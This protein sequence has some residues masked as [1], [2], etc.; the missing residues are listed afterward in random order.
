[1]TTRFSAFVGALSAAVAPAIAHADPG[2]PANNEVVV[3]GKAPDIF[4]RPSGQTVTGVGRDR[5]EGQPAFQIGDVLSSLPGVTYAFGNG[6]RDISIS[7]RGS[8]ARNTFGVRNVQVLEDGFALTQPDGLARTDLVDPHAYAAVDVAHGPSSALYG[9][10]ATGG[11]IL[12]RTR[13]GKDIDGVEIALDASSDGY[14]NAF[15]AFGFANAVF[16]GAGFLSYVTGDGFTQHT[17]YRTGT[18]NGRA[19]FSVT[20]KDRVVL[21]VINN[22]LR[23]DLSIRLSQAQF[24][25]NPFQV[26]CLTTATAGCA[27]I[28][29]FANGFN[30]TRVPLTADQAGLK[31]DDR[32]T[33]L[34]VRWEHDVDDATTWRSALVWD[35]RDINQPTSATSAVGT[36][37]SFNLTSDLT[38]RTGAVT[39]LGGVFWNR[40]DINSYSYNVMPGGNATLGG[41]STVTFGKHTNYG[42]R[43]RIELD[44]APQ[45]QV[46]GG[47][48]IERTELSAVQNAYTYPTTGSPTIARVFADRTYTNVA[49]E[50]SI[51][52]RPIENGRLYARAAG[53]Y[54]TPQATNLF[55]TPAGIPGNNTTLDAQ[56][57]KGIDIGVEWGVTDTLTVNVT[58]FYEW[59]RNELVS[60]SAGANLLNYTFNAPKSEHRGV[61]AAAEWRPFKGAKGSVAYLF[62]EQTYTEYQERLSAGAFSTQFDRAGKAIPGV[63]R[64]NVN[65]RLGYDAPAGPVR[66]LGG[67]VEM[68]WRESAFADNA[69]LLRTPGYTLFNLNAH[70]T[71]T[72][73]LGARSRL[74]FYVSAQNLTDRVYVS[75]ASNVANSISSATGL[76]NGAA[77]LYVA[78]GSIYAGQRRTVISGVKIKY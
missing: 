23:A 21:K 12:F 34:G 41:L 58:G 45:W 55:V 66:G 49:P 54:G 35:N 59:F 32:R 22:E 78:S 1:M 6:P 25:L 65:L 30:G 28:N 56:T 26:G 70:Y 62:N 69:N 47:V 29:A 18:L 5:I 74:Q 64:Q 46:V 24:R 39:L 52:Y 16:D 36:F 67:F 7:V 57:M 13:A 14:Q 72:G 15:G 11:A 50:L 76:P 61:E 10:Y 63:P 4:N 51:T 33:I 44:L 3:T 40:E 31:R 8:N 77:T 38:R 42:A 73:G 53:A 2:V 71:P 48:G 75:S 43:A 60:Q 27:S 20:S 19:T 68:N 9:N 17:A 37:P